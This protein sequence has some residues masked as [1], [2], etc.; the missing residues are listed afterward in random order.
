MSW[1]TWGA[2]KAI[3]IEGIAKGVDNYTYYEGNDTSNQQ[4]D[5]IKHTEDDVLMEVRSEKDEIDRM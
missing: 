5:D 1:L 4:D 3:G 2:G